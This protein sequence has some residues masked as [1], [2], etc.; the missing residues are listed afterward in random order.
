MLYHPLQLTR[1]PPTTNLPTGG[2][3]CSIMMVDKGNAPVSERITGKIA[4]AVMKETPV[5]QFLGPSVMSRQEMGRSAVPSIPVAFL[6]VRS[7][8]SQTRW[9]K[10][11]VNQPATCIRFYQ[12]STP[13]SSCHLIFFSVTHLDEKSRSARIHTHTRRATPTV[14]S[15]TLLR[16]RGES[17]RKGSLVVETWGSL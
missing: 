14:E 15:L 4:T 8:D 17:P 5:S 16:T 6:V 2:R 1:Y 13:L 10:L 12:T 7:A 11:R 9:R 3:Y